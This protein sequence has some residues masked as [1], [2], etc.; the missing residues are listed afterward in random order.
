MS[1]E[2]EGEAAAAATS[3]GI[4]SGSEEE[5]LED[6]V[7]PAALR[8]GVHRHDGG[9]TDEYPEGQCLPL[10]KK[11]RTNG[12]HKPWKRR[13]F[14]LR[15]GTLLYYQS[16]DIKGLPKV[17]TS[18]SEGA[19]ILR[20]SEVEAPEG[21]PLAI[22]TRNGSFFIAAPTSEE[23]DRWHAALVAARG[24]PTFYVVLPG[25]GGA[26][27]TM[28]KI[29]MSVASAVATSTVGRKVIKHYLD[30]S[31]RNLIE[32]MVQFAEA[33]VNKKTAQHYERAVF[34]ICARIAVIARENKIPPN[35]DVP[36]I[37][38]EIL[39]FTNAFLANSRDRLLRELRG[40]NAIMSEIE[41]PELL[42]SGAAI[43]RG[44]RQILE[45]NVPSKVLKRY[46]EVC[47]FFLHQDRIAEILTNEQHEELLRTVDRSVRDLLYR[48]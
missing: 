12:D 4:T 48:Y 18:L 2:G 40:P 23:Q 31:A 32:A 9:N 36:A 15:G 44:W 19:T 11:C 34:D 41:L 27:S 21:F 22:H 25:Q 28:V 38:E 14:V 5:E 10:L 16:A 42:R 13:Y 7:A 47:N 17:L 29:K 46:D 3:P 37:Y 45:P 6:E 20:Q 43:V 1:R 30:E 24:L 8:A 39:T 33:V 26:P 35:A